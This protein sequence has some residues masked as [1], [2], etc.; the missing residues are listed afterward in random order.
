MDDN[1]MPNERSPLDPPTNELQIDFDG[2]RR[3]VRSVCHGLRREIDLVAKEF[4]ARSTGQPSDRNVVDIRTRDEDPPPVSED[5]LALLKRQLDSRI[6]VR[7]A[8]VEPMT[9][10]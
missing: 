1:R 3:Q 6:Q 4:A 7:E 5:R 2:W 9:G 10:A 8:A